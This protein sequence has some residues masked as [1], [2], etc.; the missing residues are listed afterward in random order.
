M[1][2]LLISVAVGATPC[3]VTPLSAA[4]QLQ[5]PAVLVLGERKG[6]HPDLIRAERVINKLVKTAP[7]TVALEAVHRDHQGVI[8]R[9]EGG[10]LSP[11]DLPDL[12]QWST[13][14]GFDFW[15]YERLVTSSVVGATVVAVG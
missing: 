4:T 8:T 5:P 14:W 10:E 2:T 13:Y 9:Y 3:E 12:L 7:V 15:R 6:H 11:T 1:W